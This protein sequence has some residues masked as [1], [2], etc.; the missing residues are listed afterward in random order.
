MIPLAQ[1]PQAW[2][3]TAVGLK[4]SADIVWEQ[5]F[6]I[7]KRLEGGQTATATRQEAGDL[8]LL[9]PSFLL[10]YG[11]ALENALKGLLVANDPSIVGST[12]KWRIK[13]GGHDLRHLYSE[14][15]LLVKADEQE[16]LAA[17][18]QAVIWAGRYPVPRNHAGK[19]DFPIPLGPCFQGM[20]VNSVV[21][22]F[23]DLKNSC[24][25]LY[26]RILSKYPG[27]MNDETQ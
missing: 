2:H 22:R 1:C 20:D 7:F 5:W 9:I 24:D 10:L 18:T 11:L 4:R 17:L 19:P 21:P 16:L 13:G 25:A 26:L 8:Y 6:G 23:S 3:R 15:H 14:S 27:Q 12:V